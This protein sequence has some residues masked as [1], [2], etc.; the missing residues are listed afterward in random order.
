MGEGPDIQV[1]FENVL[2]DLLK[3]YD[4]KTVTIVKDAHWSF[5]RSLFRDVVDKM[6]EKLG[7]VPNG[8]LINSFLKAFEV[9]CFELVNE[10]L[11]RLRSLK[12]CTFEYTGNIM[13]RV[14]ALI[15][16]FPISCFV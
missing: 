10:V 1:I 8:A 14:E 2:N 7:P 13:K 16:A 4:M 15:L 5:Y 3:E 12:Y 9:F 11:L 6:L